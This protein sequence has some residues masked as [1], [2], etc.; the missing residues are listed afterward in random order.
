MGQH[1]IQLS[2]TGQGTSCPSSVPLSRWWD[3]GQQHFSFPA[4]KPKLSPKKAG[5]TPEAPRTNWALV[6]RHQGRLIGISGTCPSAG[7]SP[8]FCSRP[9]MVLLLHSWSTDKPTWGSDILLGENQKHTAFLLGVIKNACMLLFLASFT[10]GPVLLMG[11]SP[12]LVPNGGAPR[13]VCPL[14][15]PQHLAQCWT[16]VGIT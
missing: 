3:P 11:P 10:I 7:F 15:C 1:S 2:H 8:I 6:P 5:W 12:Q 13:P 16:R 4:P 14:L 9:I